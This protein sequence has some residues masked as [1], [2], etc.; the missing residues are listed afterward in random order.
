[1]L[2]LY[3]RI[4]RAQIEA[5]LPQVFR[6]ELAALELDHHIAAQLEVVEQQVDKK[7]VTSHIQQYL[8]AHKGKTSAQLQQK[9]GDMLD[10]GPFNRS[11][12]RLMG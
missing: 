7:L 3:L 8:P 12:L 5:Q 6:L 9:L 11:L 10:Q 2:G 4:H 1:M